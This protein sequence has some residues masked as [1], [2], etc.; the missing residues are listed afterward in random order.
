M[1]E[2]VA[3]SDLQYLLANKANIDEVKGM[4]EGMASSNE[5]TNE[6]HRMAIRLE[7]MRQEMQRR[8]AVC[9]SERDL[10]ELKKAIE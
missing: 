7:D 5:L 10:I 2:K 4:I 1:N 6:L 9:P 3:R 8:M